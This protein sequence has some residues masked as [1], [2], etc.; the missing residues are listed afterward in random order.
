MPEARE[1]NLSADVSIVEAKNNP[2]T[3]KCYFGNIFVEIP[4]EWKLFKV[5]DNSCQIFLIESDNNPCGNFR[6]F[7]AIDIFSIRDAPLP[8]PANLEQL[9]GMEVAVNN[10]PPFK[11]I[12][13]GYLIVNGMK[14]GWILS[15]EKDMER[16]GYIY[17]K[18]DNI[19]HMTL[20]SPDI[21]ISSYKNQFDG[22]V[23]KI[24]LH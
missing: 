17:F 8:H 4:K 3:Q 10:I 16:F 14:M 7:V 12:K 18:N 1:D 15:F 2:D 9:F 5:I 11:M 22:I 21:E 6:L 24:N 20:F 19:Y 23:S 13:S